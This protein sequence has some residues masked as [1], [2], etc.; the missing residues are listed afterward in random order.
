[1]IGVY[2]KHGDRQEMHTKFWSKKF[3]REEATLK[4]GGWI[5]LK[6]ATNTE[7]S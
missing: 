6:W 3:E 7:D 5:T 4:T 1:M 2:S